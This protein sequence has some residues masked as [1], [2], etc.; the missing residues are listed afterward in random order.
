MNDKILFVMSVTIVVGF[1]IGIPVIQ[2]NVVNNQD[3]QPSVYKSIDLTKEEAKN[4]RNYT[5]RD[6]LNVNE[7]EVKNTLVR[8][9]APED[10]KVTEDMIR[11]IKKD[12][13]QNM[14]AVKGFH[15]TK[16][17]VKCQR[18]YSVTVSPDC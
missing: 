17:S 14:K 10:I 16:Y 9:G 3:E 15:P 12:R 13:K 6:Y 4:L 8:N 11:K 1:F 7:K 2:G 5:V 18:S